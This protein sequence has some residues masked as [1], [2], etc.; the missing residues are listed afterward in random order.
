MARLCVVGLSHRTAPIEVREKVAFADDAVAAA[1]RQAVAL[2][3]VGEAMILSTCNRVELYAGVDE[4]DVADGLRQFLVEGRALP[5][6]LRAHLY[7]HDG[8]PALIHLFRVAASLDSMVVG[9]PQI[10][11]QV[12]QA[13][14]LADG[15]GTLGPL[16]GRVLPSAFAA[17]KRVRSETGI[18][19]SAASVASAA[20]ELAAQI[21]GALDG[22]QVLVVGAGKMGDLAARHLRAAGVAELKV[23]NRSLERAEA[24]AA[25]LGGVA[26]PWSELDP[27]LAR[28][29]IVLCSTG[30]PEPVIDAPRV[31]H[32]MRV[33]RGRWLFFIDIAVPRDV[34]PEV[35][36]IENVYLYDVDA[37]EEVAG[38]NRAGR[39][40]EAQAAEAMVRQEVERFLAAERTQ[41]VVPTI[42]ALRGRFL[43]VAHAE[44]ERALARM[45]TASERDRAQVMQ[46]ADA[47]VNKLLH[48]PLTALKRGAAADT[49]DGEALVQAV[50]VLFE[51]AESEASLVPLKS[52]DSGG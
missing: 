47:I 13:W 46:L 5:A 12:K 23:V 24:L 32:A 43:E 50:R 39:A 30:A 45:P 18:A 26:A 8:E 27:L 28:A 20:V 22:R 14:A 2:P 9:E 52:K 16:L 4:P 34:A 1:L 25:R 21:F 49:P 31:A 40:R 19:R 11:G 38:Q 3:G 35:G 36:R 7:A 37:L 51:L 33:R 17:A 41:G 44:A 29:D 15:A 10:L 48:A 42:K 6:A